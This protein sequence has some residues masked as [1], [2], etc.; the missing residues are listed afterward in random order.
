MKTIIYN[1]ISMN[2]IL[3][4]LCLVSLLVFQMSCNKGIMDLESSEGELKTRATEQKVK[5]LIP[6]SFVL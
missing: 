6:K 5:D 1:S 4:F 2:R 3:S